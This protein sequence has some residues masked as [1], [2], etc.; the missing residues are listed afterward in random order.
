MTKEAVLKVAIAALRDAIDDGLDCHWTATSTDFAQFCEDAQENI[1]DIEIALATGVIDDLLLKY[2]HEV[3]EQEEL[4]EL[5]G[6]SLD[7]LVSEMQ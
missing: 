7:A 1:K 2:C 4:G 5:G 3:I 6:K